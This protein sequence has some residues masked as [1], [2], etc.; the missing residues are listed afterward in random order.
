MVGQHTREILEW[1]GKDAATIQALKDAD[2]VTWPGDEYPW[3]V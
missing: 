3:T 1:L 2:V